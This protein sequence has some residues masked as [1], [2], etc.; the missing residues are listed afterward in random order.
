MPIKNGNLSNGK[1]TLP[2]TIATVNVLHQNKVEID[3]M[4]V[5]WKSVQ[6]P[7]KYGQRCDELFGSGAYRRRCP[8]A[9]LQGP[10]LAHR[11]RSGA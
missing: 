6:K 11:E 5:F 3:F 2:I 7:M 10:S 8:W 1:Q 4:V 9:G